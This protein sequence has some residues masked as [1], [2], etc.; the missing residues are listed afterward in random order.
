M[1]YYIT[2]STAQ[3]KTIYLTPSGKFSPKK[4]RALKVTELEADDIIDTLQDKFPTIM[5]TFGLER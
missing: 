4:Y 2:S 3:E 5:N 1:K